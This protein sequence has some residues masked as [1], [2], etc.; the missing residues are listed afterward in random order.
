MNYNVPALSLPP[1]HKSQI[2]FYGT[3]L[4]KFFKKSI[5]SIIFLFKEG[6]KNILSMVPSSKE[7][8]SVR[9]NKLLQ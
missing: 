3:K 5:K 9:D 2:N 7:L 6:M 1:P 8:Y 4:N